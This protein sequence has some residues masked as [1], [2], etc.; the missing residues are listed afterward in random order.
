MHLEGPD[1]DGE[2]LDLDVDTVA[3]QLGRL[4]ADRRAPVEGDAAGRVDLDDDGRG[5]EAGAEEGDVVGGRA[6]DA[7]GARSEHR[8]R[9]EV[10]TADHGELDGRDLLGG[11]RPVPGQ[12]QPHPRRQITD[13]DEVVVVEAPAGL[14]PQDRIGRRVLAALDGVGGDRPAQVGDRGRGVDLDARVEAHGLGPGPDTE[15]HQ[16]IDVERLRSAP[17][18]PGDD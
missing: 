8:R 4:V 5:G 6:A 12:P 11:R 16:Q 9:A 15:L 10:G 2:V 13:G 18:P 7:V 14:G 1:P 17:V 3:G